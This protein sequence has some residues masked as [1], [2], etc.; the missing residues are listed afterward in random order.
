MLG[1]VKASKTYLPGFHWHWTVLCNVH[2]GL[3]DK[4]GEGI[5]QQQI[6]I[7]KWCI[8]HYS[9]C[10]AQLLPCG[11]NFAAHVESNLASPKQNSAYRADIEQLESLASG[12]YLCLNL[13]L[14]KG[15]AAS[16]NKNAPNHINGARITLYCF[17]LQSMCAIK[18]R[19]AQPKWH[20]QSL[21]AGAA[22][23]K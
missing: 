6:P 14:L 10:K 15:R 20:Q 9:C 13:I 1:F 5:L 16:V 11:M 7:S 22:M 2:L 19:D 3:L 17:H 18:M 12:L 8:K 21:S 23:S 4:V